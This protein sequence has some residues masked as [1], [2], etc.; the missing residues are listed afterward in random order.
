MIPVKQ[1][2]FFAFIK[3]TDI[4]NSWSAVYFKSS[5]IYY[6]YEY[7][8]FSVFLTVCYYYLLRIFYGS[9]S[10]LLLL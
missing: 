2:F 3:A 6:T 9:G 10:A 1:G 5:S 4:T 7:Y 8:I